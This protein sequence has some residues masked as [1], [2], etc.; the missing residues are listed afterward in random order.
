[1]S[2]GTLGP[3]FG[4]GDLRC[5][6]LT[7]A[8]GPTDACVLAIAGGRDLS[9]TATTVI[10]VGERRGGGGVMVGDRFLRGENEGDRITLRGGGDDLFRGLRERRR[11][12]LRECVG[13]RRRAGLRDREYRRVDTGERDRRFAGPGEGDRGRPE[14]RY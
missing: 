13:E 1:M 2:A 3:G 12:G 10:G 6:G 7:R 11:G 5:R 9:R 8:E 4:D 14:K